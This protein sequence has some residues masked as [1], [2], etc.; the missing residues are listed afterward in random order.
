MAGEGFGFAG[1]DYRVSCAVASADSGGIEF[2]FC[3]A[4]LLSLAS[5]C[6]SLMRCHHAAFVLLRG[7]QQSSASATAT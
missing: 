1:Q 2:V 5:V 4:S 6:F 7:A 3:S